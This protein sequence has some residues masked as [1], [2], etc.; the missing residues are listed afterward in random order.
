M[1]TW[2]QIDIDT[3]LYESTNS[4]NQADYFLD[5]NIGVND[6]FSSAYYKQNSA[7]PEKFDI[8]INLD[9]TN[10]H[11]ALTSN[12]VVINHDFTNNTHNFSS[13]ESAGQ[14]LLEVMAT[15]IFGHPKAAAA[16]ANDTMFTGT[17]QTGLMYQIASNLC[18]TYSNTI[19]NLG[20]ATSGIELDMQ[21]LFEYYVSLGRVSSS[22]DTNYWVKMNFVAGDIFSLPFYV[23][24]ALQNAN[25][26]SPLIGDGFYIDLGRFGKDSGLGFISNGNGSGAITSTPLKKGEYEVPIKLR[27]TLV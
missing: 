25:T 6:L 5:L 17:N 22:D 9:L 12:S 16:I 8:K 7:D 11:D 14:L 1:N 15:K 27:I 21:N 26:S 20:S 18:N 2:V 10:L 19:E 13:S 23:K 24:G 4:S 3:A